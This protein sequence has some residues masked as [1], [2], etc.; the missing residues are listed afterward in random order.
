MAANET[1]QLRT[2][3]NWRRPRS[4][5]LGALGLGPTAGLFL[6]LAVAGTTLPI[7]L[8]AGIAVLVIGGLIIAPLSIRDRFGRHIGTWAWSRAAYAL[9]HWRG[10]TVYRSGILS[11]V[12]DGKCL[13]PGLAMASDMYEARDGLG[14]PFGLLHYREVDH[15]V[16]VLQCSAQG[17]TLVDQADVDQWVANWGS[18]MRQMGAEPDLLG[19]QVVVEV[20]P[21]S[22]EKLHGELQIQASD[23]ASDLSRRVMGVIDREYPYASPTLTTHV[24]IVWQA[25][26]LRGRRQPEEMAVLIGQRLPGIT[27]QLATTG[28]GAS[29][30]VSATGICELVR[31]AYEPAIAPMIDKARASRTDSGLTWSQAGPVQHVAGARSYWHDGNRSV[32]WFMGEA[33]RGEVYSEVLSSLLEAHPDIDRKRVSLVYRPHSPAESAALADRDYRAARAKT[34]ATRTGQAAA[35]AEFAAADQSRREEARGAGLTL[36][37]LVVTAT[38]ITRDGAERQLDAAEVAVENLSAP[39]RIALRRAWGSQ[40]GAFLAGL[41]IGCILPEHQALKMPKVL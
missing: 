14:R 18:F 29:T 26:S 32:T 12:P 40:D 24:A 6:L 37:G 36:F 31:M 3:G 7:N 27:Q 11:R 19:F 2:Y 28:A 5:G 10:Q 39:A 17:A 33:P 25:G 38:V 21:D 9:G 8:L 1:P 23:R 4:T 20:A 34:L 15:Y 22:G 16:A 30:P 35:E 13:L 41:P